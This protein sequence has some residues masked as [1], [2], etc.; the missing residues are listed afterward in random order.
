MKGF[1]GDLG[2]QQVAVFVF[3]QGPFQGQ[4]ASSFT[5][6]REPTC[7]MGPLEM[8]PAREILTI[9]ADGEFRSGVI[10]YGLRRTG[11]SKKASFPS[12]SWP[13]EIEVAENVL[14]GDNWE[15]VRWD[16]Q[17]DQWPQREDWKDVVEETLASLIEA[18]AV[19]AWLGQEGFF[20]D[21]PDLFNPEHMTGAVLAA[22]T[23]S[24]E[25]LC[26]IDPEKPLRSLSDSELMELRSASR[27][28][29]DAN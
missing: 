6:E 21:P 25:F 3:K 20:V 18:G 27:G 1:I 17:V 22:M 13:Q 7:Q 19:V 8:I 2:G 16:I 12:Q 9:V 26:P 15:V 5:S 24:G 23:D 11:T 10:A 4:L 29:A 14:H 28:L